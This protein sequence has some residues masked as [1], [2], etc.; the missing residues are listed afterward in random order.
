MKTII[1]LAAIGL[2]STNAMAMSAYDSK[3]MTC[4]TVHEKMAH[5]GS[6]V[7]RYPSHHPGLMMYSRTVSNSMSCLG[8]G[9]MASTSVPTSDDPSC[10]IKTCNFTTGK[11]S[12]KNH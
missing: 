6:V 9:A 5:D 3:S 7:L 11:G 10:K 1:M 12:N 2:I 4:S 8:Q